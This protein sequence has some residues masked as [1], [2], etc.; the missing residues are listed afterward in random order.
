MPSNQ[1]KFALISHHETVFTDHKAD[2]IPLSLKPGAGV[3]DIVRVEKY[4]ERYAE[5][6]AKWGLERA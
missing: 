6:N 3:V 4:L 1:K 2:A 5:Y